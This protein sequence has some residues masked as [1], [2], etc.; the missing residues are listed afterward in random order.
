[1]SRLTVELK[2]HDPRWVV[3]YKRESAA[4]AEALGDAC[5]AIHHIGSTA[6]PGICAKPVIDMLAVVRN[7]EVLDSRSPQVESLGYEAMGEFGIPGRRYF[8]KDDAPGN[9]TH[10]IHTFA[11]GSPQ[12]VRHIGF[13]D[14]L[15][16]HPGYAEEYDALKQRLAAQ[17]PQDISAYTD[18]K[19]EFIARVDALAAE[20]QS[21]DVFMDGPIQPPAPPLLCTEVKIPPPRATSPTAQKCTPTAP[22]GSRPDR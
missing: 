18:G 2:P 17:F 21:S 1:M 15:R 14:F 11:A 13:R 22:S 12:I 10:Q 16:A 19:D 4:V 7:V 3:D 5:V 6:I 8:R 9:R 20:W